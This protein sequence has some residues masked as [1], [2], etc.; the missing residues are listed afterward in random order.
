MSE[1]RTRRGLAA[2]KTTV[3]PAMLV[4][5]ALLSAAAV[6]VVLDCALR[7]GTTTR[8]QARLAPYQAGFAA[9]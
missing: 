5:A 8:S 6:Y 9:R 1:Q 2:I 7:G 3:R 4:G